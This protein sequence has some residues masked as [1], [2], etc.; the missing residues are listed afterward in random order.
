MKRMEA[1]RQYEEAQKKG[2]RYYRSCIARGKH[3][4]PQVLNDVFSNM[5][6]ASQVKLGVL[7]IPLNRVIGTTTSGRSSSFA[8]N[9]MP[10]LDENTEF[11]VKWIALCEHHLG[12]QGICDPIVCYEYMGHFYVTEGNKRVSVLK[13]YDAVSI[14]ASVTRIVPA[15]SDDDPRIQVYYEFMNFFQLSRLYDVNFTRP[16]SYAKLQAA[17]GFEADHI[18]SA[19]ERSEFLYGFRRFQDAFQELNTE[20]L[21]ITAADALL[22]WLEMNAIEDLER[23]DLNKS[24]SSA[25]PDVQIFARGSSI[26]LSTAPTAEERN[27]LARL[28]GIGKITHL[29]AAFIYAYDPL[30]SSW[31][32]AH[33]AGREHL[34]QIMADRVTVHTYLCTNRDPYDVMEEAIAD[35]AQILFATTPPM[36]DACRQ[37]AARYPQ[38]KV[39]NCSLSMPYAGIRTYYSR[40][41]EAKFITG[42][43]IGAMGEADRIGYVANYPIIGTVT[44]VNAFAAGVR[45]TNPRAKVDLR[46]T[47]LPGNPVRDLLDEGITVISNRDSMTNDPHWIWEWGTY[48]V[49]GNGSLQPLVSPRWNWG[50]FY[51]GVV[52]SVFNGSWNALEGKQ[53]QAVNYWWGLSSGVIDVTLSPDLPEGICHLVSILKNGLINGSIDPFE[54]KMVDQNGSVR[55]D[56]SSR[57]SAEEIMN[58]DWLLDNVE[59]IVPEYEDLLPVSQPLVRLLGLHRDQLQPLSKEGSA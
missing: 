9:F 16:G 30:M 58:M 55:S 37:I 43:V 54:C 29:N 21:E 44:A 31:T 12:G 42:A 33:D 13:S 52:E 48:K 47:C 1:I 32:A 26:A 27:A 59:G 35:G 20:L 11:A 2:L 38:V 18:W 4:Y 40:I 23:T 24:L 22:V 17:L 3:P 51:E 10:L 50:K 6:A 8:G 46:W 15:W 25:W 7:D 5:M 34:E 49:S 56:G 14:Q 53:P 36:I 39:L 57:L 28:F 41:Y 19:E 45:L